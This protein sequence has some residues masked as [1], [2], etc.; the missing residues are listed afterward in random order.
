ML[1]V[2]PADQNELVNGVVGQDARDRVLYDEQRQHRGRRER[3]A[4]GSGEVAGN[5]SRRGLENER[6]HRE[7]GED[8]RGQKGWPRRKCGQLIGKPGE[9]VFVLLG[10]VTSP[11]FGSK[12]GPEGGDRGCSGFVQVVH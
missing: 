10:W 12:Q 8:N 3:S 6:S 11:S 1:G 2:N 4:G 9:R 5:D 7:G